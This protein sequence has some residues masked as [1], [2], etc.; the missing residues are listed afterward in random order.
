MTHY[1]LNFENTTDAALEFVIYQS[2][3]GKHSIFS[4]KIATAA[5]GGEKLHVEW[6]LSYG[7]AI[8]KQDQH[9]RYKI[10]QTVDAALGSAWEV[11]GGADGA[12]EI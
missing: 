1:T 4:W 12:V 6:D 7:V 3:V 11:V 10:L 2:Y 5:A 8:A 9:G